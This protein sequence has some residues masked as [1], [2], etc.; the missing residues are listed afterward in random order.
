MSESI[1]VVVIEDETPNR[2][3]Y[4]RALSKIGYRVAAFAQAEPV[5]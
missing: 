5:Q 1:H 2:E 4:E 3:S